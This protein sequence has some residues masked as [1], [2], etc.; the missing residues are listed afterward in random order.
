MLS[1]Q[2]CIHS[3][4]SAQGKLEY[5]ESS[6]GRHF[7]VWAL[8]LGI[9]GDGVVT[10]HTWWRCLANLEWYVFLHHTALHVAFLSS[11]YVPI[12]HACHDTKL[13]CP[14]CKGLEEMQVELVQPCLIDQVKHH[15]IIKCNVT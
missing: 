9:A 5:A 6:E 11:V 1:M 13:R 7:C 4:T 3:G 10:V 14:G 15:A 2:S 8:I 12:L